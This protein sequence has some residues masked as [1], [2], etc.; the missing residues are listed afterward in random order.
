MNTG[1][2]PSNNQPKRS[3][4]ARWWYD[5]ALP[6][7][8]RSERSPEFRRKIRQ[9]LLRITAVLVSFMF[10]LLLLI[11]CTGWYTSRS[12]FCRSC[13]IMEPYYDSWKAS[14]HKDVP[15]I[16]CHFAPGFGENFRGKMLG[17][18]QLAST[19]PAAK[20]HDRRRR[21]LTPVACGPDAMRL[22]C[23]PAGKYTAGSISTTLRIWV[24]HGVEYNSAAPVATARWYRAKS[25]WP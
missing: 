20:V 22:V 2:A 23:Y 19:L 21:F 15:C 17:L 6:S 14:T 10:L 24:K 18:V 4:K 9:V 25:T 3:G 8:R 12:D 1:N 11:F 16:E 7:V 5:S 13:H